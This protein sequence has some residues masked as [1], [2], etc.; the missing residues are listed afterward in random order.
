MNKEIN[1]DKK[2]KCLY[3]IRDVIHGNINFDEF[4]KKI[5]DHS[6]FQRLRKINQLGFLQYVFP[7]SRHSRFEH[8]IGVMHLSGLTLKKIIENQY[9]FIEKIKNKTP[10]FNK[11]KIISNCQL[12]IKPYVNR[13]LRTAALLHDIGHGPFSHAS[14]IFMVNINPSDFLKENLPPWLLDSYR[15]KGRNKVVVCH[16]FFSIKYTYEILKELKCSETFIRDVLC[17]IDK[18][19]APEKNSLLSLE[20]IHILLREIISNEIDVDRMDYLLRDSH[21]SGV[22]YGIY[23]LPRLIENLCF[24]QDTKGIPHMAITQK[25]IYAFEDYLYRRHQMYLQVYIQRTNTAFE[26]MLRELAN[27][28]RINL[29]LDSKTFMQINDQSFTNW[30]DSHALVQPKIKKEYLNLINDLFN[31]R[32]PWKAVY[33]IICDETQK[34]KINEYKQ[35]KK[36][37]SKEKISAYYFESKRMLTKLSPVNNSVD[38]HFKIIYQKPFTDE[39]ILDEVNKHSYLVNK[40]KQKVIIN[41]IFVKSDDVKK[42][43]R[44]FKKK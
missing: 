34:M 41:R 12:L 39:Y 36:Q 3:Q 23:D 42:L 11:R 19:L 15:N 1:W 17:L 10:Y 2:Q 32:K 9:Q 13:C 16:E 18:D 22:G 20:S 37:L 38:N 8:S 33:Q 21:Y 43:K 4:E 5:I 6:Y 40:L 31:K 28:C 44:N 30:L 35:I 24:Y 29:P 26:R 14:E 27:L 25:G 7:G